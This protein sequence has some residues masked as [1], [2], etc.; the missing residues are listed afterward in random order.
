MPNNH[1]DSLEVEWGRFD[2][3]EICT[4]LGRGKYSEVFKGLNVITGQD[5]V[6][7]ILKPT[8][9]E[10]IKR[11]IKILNTVNGGPSITNLV[12]VVKDPGSKSP[13]LILEWIPNIGH[14]TFYPTL[15][16]FDF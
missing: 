11:E 9:L 1:Y 14:R 15:K 16:P 7:K 2:D 3:Y 4:K 13:V 6:V 8:K 10:K 5:V 12:E